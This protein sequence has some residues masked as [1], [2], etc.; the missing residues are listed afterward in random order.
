MS[1][2]QDRR[3]SERRRDE[4]YDAEITQHSPDSPTLTPDAIWRQTPRSERTRRLTRLLANLVGAGG[5]TFFAWAGLQHYQRT[6]SFVGAAFF[7]EQLWIVVAYL[8]R[9]PAATVSPRAGDWLLAF[10]GT[11]GGVLL[12]PSGAHSHAGVVAGLDVQLLGLV[13]CVVSF[14]ALGRSFGFA[15]ANRGLKQRGPYAIVRHPIYASYFL[16]LL[17]YVLQSFSWRNVVVMVFVC[18]CDVG[19]AFAEER[20]LTTSA[21][22]AQYRY[23]VRWRL[24]PGVW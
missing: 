22:Y 19:R 9:R 17:G 18:S 23:R 1:R 6:H 7:A 4:T 11:F 14:A 13:I 20:F 8:V 21:H 2:L 5:A 3:T 16:L 15:A 10:G 12:R 24:L